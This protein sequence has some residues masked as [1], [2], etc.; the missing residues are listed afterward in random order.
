MV[1]EG[2]RSIVRGDAGKDRRITVE[3]EVVVCDQNMTYYVF[4]LLHVCFFFF[5][6]D[7]VV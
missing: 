4:I 7:K 2:I 5:L 6:I 1:N 3:R